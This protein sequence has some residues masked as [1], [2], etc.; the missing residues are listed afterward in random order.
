LVPESVA[1]D[2]G[3][4]GHRLGIDVVAVVVDAVAEL[5]GP[6]MD[7]GVGIIA[8]TLLF[9]ETGAQGTGEIA[10]RAAVPVPVGIDPE[11]MVQALVD[12]PVAVV[13]ELVAL[14]D[15]VRMHEVAVI[16]AVLGGRKAV[17]VRVG[18]ALAASQEEEREGKSHGPRSAGQR[19]RENLDCREVGSARDSGARFISFIHSIDWWARV[20]RSSEADA[21]RPVLF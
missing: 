6:R 18:F 16:V 1:V 20:R 8:I 11:G 9:D 4:P 19:R 21:G 10:R 2:V 7:I 14:L 3:V 15:P 5:L 13:V 17:A 12:V